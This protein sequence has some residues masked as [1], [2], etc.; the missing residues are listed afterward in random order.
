MLDLLLA[1]APLTPGLQTPIL[2]ERHRVLA[3]FRDETRSN[4]LV[5]VDGDGDLDLIE[6]NSFRNRLHLW[7][8]GRFVA[9]LTGLPVLLEPTDELVAGDFDGDGNVDL[10]LA[11]GERFAVD[12]ENRLLLGDGAGG[13][14]E[15]VGAFPAGALDS[16]AAAAA[17]IDGDGDLD[18]AVA[19]ASA[20]NQLL[21]NDGSGLFTEAVGVVPAR[22]DKTT[23]V[24]FL[25]VEPD[26]DADLLFIN[27][28]EP[29]VLLRN[30]G[31]GVFT[32]VS[33]LLPPIP[34]TQQ[35][36]ASGDVD[37]DGDQDVLVPGGLWRND[38]AAGFTELFLGF[39]ILGDPDVALIDVNGDG[40]LDYLGAQTGL[41][42]GDGA[43]G[44]QGV[45]SAF[46][47]SNAL[48][49]ADLDGDGDVDVVL[50]RGE[51]PNFGIPGAGQA[52][53]LS[54]RVLL[55][56]GAG[57]FTDVTA[58]EPLLPD[59]SRMTVDAA[60]GDFDGDGRIDVL[61]ALGESTFGPLPK[62]VLYRNAGP[63][64]FEE[65]QAPV[66]GDV[67]RT[68]GVKA[69][70]ADGDGD[71]DAFAFGTSD[72][73]GS[74]GGIQLYSN[75]GNGQFTRTQIQGA[76]EVFDVA[77]GDL[78]ADG[79]LDV[80]AA[81]DP[82]QTVVSVPPLT[83]LNDGAGGFVQDLGAFTPADHSSRDVELA[84][85]DGD[86]VLDALFGNFDGSGP[87]S[88]A[89]G[90]DRL[91]LGSGA[92]GFTFAPAQ[93]PA[94]LRDTNLLAVGDIDL[95]GDLD[96]W[97][98][99]D[100]ADALLLNDGSGTFLAGATP[101]PAAAFGASDLALVDVDL[102]GRLDALAAGP[103]ALFLNQGGA[104][105]TDATDRLPQSHDFGRGLAI[106]DFDAD[107]DQDAFLACIGEV[108]PSPV[109]LFAFRGPDRL[110]SNR[111]R[112]LVWSRVPSIG[113]PLDLEFCAGPGELM[114]LY[115]SL[116][117][118]PLELGFG[119][120][121]LDPASAASLGLYPA[122]PGGGCRTISLP[123]PNHPGLVGQ[124]LFTQ[125][126]VFDP[127]TQ[128]LWATGLE[129]VPVTNL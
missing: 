42:F 5:D 128:D 43:G 78:D 13:F 92:G 15:R 69:G 74:G 103:D 19:N 84:D 63:G 96:V 107:G 6:A 18:V 46:G 24:L 38:G 30:Q 124:L 21:L 116:G 88:T 40:V 79:D 65:S 23:D 4:A 100:D 123:V 57:S 66:P 60:A 3:D 33:G 9:Q 119:T 54:G 129:R 45:T 93:L 41:A 94:D 22:I 95:D 72:F 108:Q 62:L 89:T 73:D 111:S 56:D 34:A 114:G 26:G 126:F 12:Y 83:M 51:A 125:G 48:S 85:F 64:S 47:P 61:T 35:S 8:N 31:A 98:G 71:L 44:F 120:A 118:L 99:H 102:D 20:Q 127:L 27:D 81:G 25:D 121:W 50:G 75:D 87:F 76:T 7:E 104:L 67:T 122:A 10:V 39:A 117:S 32:D 113:Q 16:R 91:F 17:D 97:A 70:D 55:G 53:P 77:L 82:S 14:T 29:S 28:G 80:V 105:F 115:V 112:H 36:A 101:L 2:E 110:W 11:Q 106:A 1:L 86:G 49:A 52:F 109:T 37:G 68:I 59:V 90:Q 58:L